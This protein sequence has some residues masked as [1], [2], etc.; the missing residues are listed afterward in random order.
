[1]GDDEIYAKN[2]TTV[3]VT[4]SKVSTEIESSAVT[5][6]YNVDKN[7]I[8][9]LKDANGNP[10]RGANITVDLNG[11]KTYTT[12]ENGQVNVSTNGLK[13]VKIYPATITFAGDEK[14]LKSTARVNVGVKKATPRITSFNKVFKSTVTNKVYLVALKDNRGNAMKNTRVTLRVGGVTYSA[15]TNA[16]GIAVFRLT[17][18]TK[19]GL[20]NALARYAGNSY[21]NA[22]AKRHL[23]KSPSQQSPKEAKTKQW[24]KKSK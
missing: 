3:N 1:M 7:L 12:D 17:K 10:I 21:Y 8:V 2:S 18:L 19:V 9:T 23:S 6:V 22:V 13:P 24:S 15:I 11:E 20:Y 16:K 14:Y 4:V 5:T